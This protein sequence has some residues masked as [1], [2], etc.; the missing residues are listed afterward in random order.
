MMSIMAKEEVNTGR[1]IEFDYMKGIFMLFI[2]LIHAYQAT[3]SDMSLPVK[4]I[5]AFATMSGAAIYI[6]VMGFGISYSPNLTPAHLAKKGFM[7]V[8]YQYLTNILYVI[9]L[10][11]PYPFVKSSLTPEGAEIFD[12]LKCVYIQYINI[13]FTAGIIC[14]VLALLKKLSA[15]T[16]VYL[17]LAA[18]VA[19][20]A[21]QIYGTEVEVPVLGYVIKLLIGEDIFISF[22]PLYFLPYALIGVASG[23]LYRRIRDKS[24]FYRYVI[25]A[26][27]VIVIA[28]WVSVFIRL[29]PPALFWQEMDYSYTCPDIWHVIASLAHIFLFAGLLYFFSKHHRNQASS[30]ILFYSKNISLYYALHL[31][32]YLAALGFHGYLE[33]DSGTCLIL[34]L[35][36]MAVTEV[37]VRTIQQ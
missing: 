25:C 18:A 33:F 23:K 28:W 29:R 20:A 15:P 35:V 37:M 3:G 16:F 6:F 12:L 22:T 7:L 30:Q 4:F 19:L 21:P 2:F 26:C 36:S 31:T 14:L 13:F 9:S 34:A 11:I 17:I 10:C 8:L 27:A 1:Q 32:V 5:Y 24:V